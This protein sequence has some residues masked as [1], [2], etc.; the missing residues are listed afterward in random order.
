MPYQVGE[1]QHGL[2]RLPVNFKTAAGPV[3]ITL[4]KNFELTPAA[5]YFIEVL[6]DV[7]KDMTNSQM[8]PDEK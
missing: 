8:I 4:R 3:G 5:A 2:T 6:R 7:A 1:M